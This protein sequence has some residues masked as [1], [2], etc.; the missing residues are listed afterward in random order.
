VDLVG[1]THVKE[2]KKDFGYDKI[3]TFELAKDFKNEDYF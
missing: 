2:A 3:N 1:E